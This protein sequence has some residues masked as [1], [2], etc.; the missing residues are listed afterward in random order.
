VYRH[1]NGRIDDLFIDLRNG[2]GLTKQ[3]GAFSEV[4]RRLPRVAERRSSWTSYM[5]AFER[6]AGVTLGRCAGEV[7]VRERVS[8]RRGREHRWWMSSLFIDLVIDNFIRTNTIFKVQSH[9][10][11][12][13]LRPEIAVRFKSDI[14]ITSI[15]MR[16]CRRC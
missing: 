7:G 1:L 11:D 4:H 13:R 15:D 5:A 3:D 6:Y 14:A 16:C 12:R 8:S 10:L 9:K 2:D